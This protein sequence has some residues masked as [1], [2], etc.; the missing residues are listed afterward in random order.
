MTATET[1]NDTR[2][3]LIA[4]AEARLMS[5]GWAALRMRDLAEAE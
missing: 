2:G 1:T 3:A 5:D 4:A